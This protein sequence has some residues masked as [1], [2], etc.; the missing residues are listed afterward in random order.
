MVMC[1]R[2]MCVCVCVDG[3]SANI[4]V[5]SAMLSISYRS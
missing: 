5:F 3:S 1:L 4:C 2:S